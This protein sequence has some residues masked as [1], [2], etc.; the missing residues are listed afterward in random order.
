MLTVFL[1]ILAFLVI[2]AILILVHEF[3]HFSAAKLM[4]VQVDEFGLGFPPR[5]KTWRR[6]R[7][8]YS[9]NAIPLG[10]FVKMQGENGQDAEP[11][12]F[13]SKAPWRRFLILIAGPS[14][15][16]LLAVVLF[17]FAFMGG[18]PRGLTVITAVSDNSPA[19]AAGLH[20]GDRI[21]AVDGQSVQYL[22]ELQAVVDAHLGHALELRVQR[23]PGSFLTT[24]VP[25]QHPPKNQG[26]I[27]I[28]LDR[29]VT[30]AYSPSSAIKQAV[31]V[32]GNT[33]QAVPA[34]FQTLAR[35]DTAPVS[36][37]IGIAHQTTLVVQNEPANGFGSILLFVG[38]L[39]AS[40]G[41]LNLLPIPAL[42]GGRIVFVLLS[43]IRRRNLDP[44]VEGLIH[45]AGMAMLLLLILFVS[46]QDIV[47][48]ISGG[49]F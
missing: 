29:T 25:R 38:F 40:L 1:G 45:I 37:P 44:E 6:G 9:L 12:S 5:L 43:W 21:L 33:M 24:L 28:G 39:S 16:L 11:D 48:W 42:D 13:G 27:G 47:R 18:S 20:P 17:F 46:Y 10:G 30:V 31:S 4:G 15:N 7:T 32:I 34:L 41:V 36:G 14:M 3:G 35:H 26:P 2:L 19:A 22:D 8:L 23:G 49:S